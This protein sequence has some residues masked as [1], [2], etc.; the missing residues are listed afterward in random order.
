MQEVAR[1]RAAREAVP[2]RVGDQVDGGRRRR[3][4]ASSGSA[5][6]GSSQSAT[7]FRRRAAAHRRPARSRRRQVAHERREGA[8]RPVAL[9]VGR[10]AARLEQRRPAA[11]PRASVQSI[12]SSAAPACSAMRSAVVAQRAP[13]LRAGRRGID[14][15]AA[16]QQVAE[17]RCGASWLPPPCVPAS[18]ATPSHRKWRA[19]VSATYSRRRSSRRRA[20]STASS[21]ASDRPRSMRRSPSVVRPVE[22][23]ACC[24]VLRARKPGERQ[25]H[26][27]VFQALRLVHRDD[28]DQFGVA[29]QAQQ[30]SSPPPRCAGDLLGEPADQR[31]LAIELA[32]GRLQQLG[33]VQQ[34]GQPA[35]AAAAL[36]A[37]SAPAG[38]SSWMKRRSMA[39]T[40]WRCH[41][42]CSGLEL[43]DARFPG[44]FV[45]RQP[46][47][48][49]QRQAGGAGGQARRA[50]AR[51]RADWPPRAASA[52]RRP[53]RRCRTPNPGPTGRPTR[54]RRRC[55]ARRTA[56][57]SRPVAHQHRDVGR[58]QAARSRVAR[59]VEAGRSDRSAAPT[60]CS[61]QWCGERGCG[62]RRRRRRA[63]CSSTSQRLVRRR[64]TPTSRSA[65]PVR[66][67]PARTAAD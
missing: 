18:A 44:H 11:S 40:P 42:A 16:A 55:S 6:L 65:R 66:A 19:R 52:A 48:F 30:R 22:E 14:R 38:R 9:E 43:L 25:V 26:Q 29:F 4:S 46:R 61:A 50:P 37:A 12:G 33:Q 56:A 3:L 58:P 23:A 5:R 13:V 28:L 27:R 7:A 57:A 63:G 62:S 21:A 10:V 34:V 8:D 53:P 20:R 67:R 32:A 39:S 24:A 41:T 15:R 1:H 59:V 49:G 35:L 64:P 47:Q 17:R 2:R 45:A 51:R 36:A 31:L 60:M 54:R